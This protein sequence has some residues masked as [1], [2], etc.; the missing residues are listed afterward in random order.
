MNEKT[1]PLKAW[2]KKV[3]N[4]NYYMDNLKTTLTAVLTAV[5]GLATYKGWIDESVGSYVTAAGVAL[6]GYFCADKPSE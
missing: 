3:T 2:L 6:F 1:K 4:K 5:V